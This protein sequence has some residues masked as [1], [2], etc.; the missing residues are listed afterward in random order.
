MYNDVQ[1]I[2][3]LVQYLAH[4]MPDVSAYTAP[5][6]GCVRNHHPFEW[7]PLLDKCL[8]STKAL[9]C[10]IPVL[11]LVDPKNLDL[12]WVITDGSKSG[13]GAVYGQ[14][15]SGRHAGLQVSCQI[16]SV[17]PSNTTEHMSMKL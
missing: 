8:Q 7:M 17:L 4:Y 12:I 16:N 2:L 14:G 11:R 3:G 1:R 9:A 10:K 5:L 15:Q 6:A 13:I